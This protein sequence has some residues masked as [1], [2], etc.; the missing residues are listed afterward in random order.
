MTSDDEYEVHV[1]PGFTPIFWC[2]VGV[3]IVLFYYSLGYAKKYSSTAA[4]LLT[5]RRPIPSTLTVAIIVLM[6][7]LCVCC[8][9]YLYA[10]VHLL[11]LGI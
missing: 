4:F 10:A 11:Q 1:L 9:L 7:F 2:F 5:V 6:L 8:V 3:G